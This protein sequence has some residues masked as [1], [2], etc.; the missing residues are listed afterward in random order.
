M[1]GGS[2]GV[3]VAWEGP[4]SN[5]TPDGMR[6]GK[7]EVL[8]ALQIQQHYLL[9]GDAHVNV[10]REEIGSAHQDFERS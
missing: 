3:A 6:E 7:G 4:A 9:A 8:V 2:L 1:T 10:R 5:P